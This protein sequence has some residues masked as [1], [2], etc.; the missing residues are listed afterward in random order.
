MLAKL[1]ELT[2]VSGSPYPLRVT[3]LLA[4]GCDIVGCLGGVEQ[5]VCVQVFFEDMHSPLLLSCTW[6]QLLMCQCLC[7][8]HSHVTQMWILGEHTSLNHMQAASHYSSKTMHKHTEK[9]GDE[10]KRECKR[11]KKGFDQ[12]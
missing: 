5:S 9:G 3:A 7:C 1:D 4:C 2:A 6:N 11:D 8:S 10:R 12:P